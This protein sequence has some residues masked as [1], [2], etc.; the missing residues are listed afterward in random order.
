[1]TAVLT[2]KAKIQQA[3]R[4]KSTFSDV[5]Y[6]MYFFIGRSNPWENDT[7]PPASADS[8]KD[9]MDRWNSMISLKKIIA[10]DVA[11][12]I[13]LFEWDS[14]GETRYVEYSDDDPD[15][16]NHPTAEEVSD[17]GSDY[18]P[19]SFYVMT[20]DYNVYKCISNGGF[21]ESTEKPTGTSTSIIETDD[22]YKWKYMFTIPTS[23][24][25]KWA[26]PEFIP[27]KTL[28]S[29]DG[30]AQWDVQAAAVDGAVEHIQVT[31]AG[32]GYTD[33]DA[34]T[35][36]SGGGSTIRLRSGASGSDDTY[37]GCMVF[38]DSGTGAG[39]YREI[40]DYVGATKD[41]TVSVAW[42]TA[43]DN[44]SVYVVTPKL[45]VSGG[46]GTGLVGRVYTNAGAIS[47]I[48]IV[49]AGSAYRISEAITL[50][51]SG[52][53]GTGAEVRAVISPLGGHG[54]NPVEEL[55]GFYSITNVKLDFDETDF[56]TKNDYR[57]M[58]IVSKVL[59]YGTTTLSS[60]S[61]LAATKGLTCNTL[62]GSFDED[63]EIVG[64][65]SGT[66]ALVVQSDEEDAP[67]VSIK[68][69]QDSDTQFKAFQV[70]ET[71][72]GLTS[73]ATAVVTALVNPEIV[74]YNGRILHVEQRR[75]LMRSEDSYEDIKII[76]EH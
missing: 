50:T 64:G 3:E 27:V 22:G 52:G 48:G 1:M 59:N 32:S 44:T 40:S 51:I 26:T 2:A 7:E 39:Q 55:G 8:V 56:P 43:P 9:E 6:N 70:A 60:A 35:A 67:N 57:I 54:S 63:E 73:G 76:I 45:T 71:V 72:T 30:S 36:Q 19:G 49:A 33:V 61:T 10:S 25:L 74:K 65:T 58:G 37:N 62:V 4:F 14:T 24:V 12:A 69:T 42:G 5:L 17:A 46:T 21:V 68:F 66:H 29:D 16:F 75:P 31:D 34:G 28:A 15:L 11:H 53:G 47:K 13:P 23:E 20:D 38:I 18:T 41:A